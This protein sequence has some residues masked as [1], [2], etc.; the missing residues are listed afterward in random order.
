[1]TSQTYPPANNNEK[2][3]H[4][5]YLLWARMGQS[6]T[7]KAG[8]DAWLAGFVPDFVRAIVCIYEIEPAVWG[9]VGQDPRVLSNPDTN[10]GLYFYYITT[11]YLTLTTKNS[12]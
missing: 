12:T 1:M 2:C 4:T 11:F 9:R 3:V 8:I 7:V 6:D 10:Q 5:Y